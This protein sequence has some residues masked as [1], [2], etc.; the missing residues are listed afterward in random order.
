VSSPQLLP[1]IAQVNFDEMPDIETIDK[2]LSEV[3]EGLNITGDLRDKMM[4]DDP[5][6]KWTLICQHQKP[7]DHGSEKQLKEPHHYIENLSKKYVVVYFYFYLL[8]FSSKHQLLRLIWL[9]FAFN[10]KRRAENLG[11]P[12]C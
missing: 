1:K 4:K 5:K 2:Q 7:D 8:L 11:C 6:R 12:P 9:T 10:Q 3:L